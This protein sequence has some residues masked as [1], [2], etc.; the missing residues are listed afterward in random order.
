MYKQNRILE[1]TLK[2]AAALEKSKEIIEQ[3]ILKEGA[4]IYRQQQRLLE[5]KSKKELLLKQKAKIEESLNETILK[6]D[7]LRNKNNQHN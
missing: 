4:N 1:D 7:Q 2:E 6:L 3:E 5:S